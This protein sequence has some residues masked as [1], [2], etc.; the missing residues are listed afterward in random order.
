MSLRTYNTELMKPLTNS[1]FTLVGLAVV[2]LSNGCALTKD[3]ISLNY[4]AQSNVAQIAGA[5]QV[6]VKI[7]ITD[8]RSSKDRVGSKKNGYGQEMAAIIAKEDVTDTVKK[9]IETELSQ[10]GFKVS[11]GDTL[12]MIQLVKFLNDFKPGFWSGDAVAEVMMEVQLKKVDGSIAYSKVVSG[13]GKNPSIQLASGAN[14]KVALDAALQNAVERMFGD[15]VFIDA[16]LKTA[17]R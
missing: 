1:L 9:A 15:P 13:E 5:D 2:A 17:K 14:A 7:D 11:G 3:Y 16:L 6:S 8:L 4:V 10:R 12:L